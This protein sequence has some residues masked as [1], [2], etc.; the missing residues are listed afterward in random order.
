[1]SVLLS[2]SQLELKFEQIESI[3]NSKYDGRSKRSGYVENQQN[4]TPTGS[5]YPSARSIYSTFSL[6]G[7]DFTSMYNES[8]FDSIGPN[9]D[10]TDPVS[11][12]ANVLLP[13]L[14]ESIKNE[15]NEDALNILIN[16]AL[17][18]LTQSNEFDRD[19]F[20]E[21]INLC[22]NEI[23][24]LNDDFERDCILI[25]MLRQSTVFMNEE[26]YETF[27][28][29]IFEDLCDKFIHVFSLRQEMNIEALG[30]MLACIRLW[31][32]MNSWMLHKRQI[33]LKLSA[34][35]KLVSQ[36]I[37]TIREK[38]RES[39]T[40]ICDRHSSY[41]ELFESEGTLYKIF[42]RQNYFDN[43]EELSL[44][45][46][47][48]YQE[49]LGALERR[50]ELYDESE[51][52]FE[53]VRADERENIS[54][55]I[56]KTNQDATSKKESAVKKQPNVLGGNK[57]GFKPSEVG[58]LEAEKPQQNK[59]RNLLSSIQR[60]VKNKKNALVENLDNLKKDHFKKAEGLILPSS[61]TSPA[62][63]IEDL[64]NTGTE[65]KP[66][67]SECELMFKR[68]FGTIDISERILKNFFIVGL[69][70]FSYIYKTLSEP[71]QDHRTTLLETEEP[72]RT[73][74][75]ES[76]YVYVHKKSTILRLWLGNNPSVYKLECLN[77]FGSN[78]YAVVDPSYKSSNN[79]VGG[80]NGTD[81]NSGLASFSCSKTSLGMALDNAE[82]N[83][84][85]SLERNLTA[86]GVVKNTCSDTSSDFTV[87]SR[88]NDSGKLP[89]KKPIKHNSFPSYKSST[90]FADA[91]T[92][93]SPDLRLFASNNRLSDLFDTPN[94]NREKI[95]T[96][97]TSSL[98]DFDSM[99]P[100]DPSHM[101][102]KS[103]VLKFFSELN[104]T[105]RVL[106]HRATYSFENS[107]LIHHNADFIS[108][109]NSIK[110]TTPQITIDVGFLHLTQ[111]E[112][113]STRDF[114]K[115]TCNF[116]K[117][118]QNL[119]KYGNCDP[120]EVLLLEN[121]TFL[122]SLSFGYKLNYFIS[123]ES[124][125]SN[126]NIYI[127]CV[128]NY[129]ISSMQLHH[130]VMRAKQFGLI[131]VPYIDS[132]L[133]PRDSFDSIPLSSYSRINDYGGIQSNVSTHPYLRIFFF[134]GH[135]A[136]SDDKL[137]QC[138][139]AIYGS[140]SVGLNTG[141]IFDD[142]IVHIDSLHFL[143]SLTIIELHNS[144]SRRTNSELSHF[145]QR[146]LEIDRLVARSTTE[147]LKLY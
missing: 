135:V 110:R 67:L 86:D 129:L 83:S 125:P 95:S 81:S 120:D 140:G 137:V 143:L 17:M 121:R 23:S 104:S 57:P 40:P 107:S 82:V 103:R 71:V 127:V 49:Q 33:V 36:I 65:N 29:K 76:Y 5:L 44:K 13:D 14:I 54:V 116:S 142:C 26:I 41:Y 90:L 87:N 134:I 7:H 19:T 124:A 91:E 43:F 84:R 3:K 119:K 72:G 122:P 62:A 113:G 85:P 141:P 89:H 56:P 15:K 10:E 117:L 93:G 131:G 146:K 136:D 70:F 100:Q 139:I 111:S 69:D 21:I 16:S 55:E 47:H 24:G 35:W 97:N 112:S 46:Y 50:Y 25:R 144:L 12:I 75:L 145:D 99:A 63:N 77:P 147:T 109:F 108:T 8:I 92:S 38:Y 126:A 6:H 52:E 48:M 1:M 60:G 73:E 79:S 123:N 105:N 106:P 102:E 64:F 31:A 27:M 58:A 68:F 2:I 34:I 132:L 98:T 32:T 18:V 80:Q 133:K 28:E 74:M 94:I 78:T 22:V 88:P 61:R 39:P 37:L 101:F 66:K 30:D 20:V 4:V 53:L 130:V 11:E 45:V 114:D 115:N 128:D 59:E 118:F 138:K 96:Q 51:I 42:N 9:I